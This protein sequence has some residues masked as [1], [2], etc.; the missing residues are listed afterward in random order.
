MRGQIPIEVY[1]TIRRI[2]FQAEKKYTVNRKELGAGCFT[3]T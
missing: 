3:G 2:R 1:I